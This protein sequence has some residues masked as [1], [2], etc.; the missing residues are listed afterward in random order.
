VRE[1]AQHGFTE[2]FIPFRNYHKTMEGLG[3]KI[4]PVKTIHELLELIN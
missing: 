1:S 4:I 3:A 2:I